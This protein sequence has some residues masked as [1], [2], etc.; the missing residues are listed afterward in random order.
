L[1]LLLLLLLPNQAR[2]LEQKREWALQLKRVILENYDAVIP[3]HARQLVLQLGQDQRCNQER[4]ASN[5]G[6][7]GYDRGDYAYSASASS[8]GSGG[9]SSAAHHVKRHQ[10]SAPE[11]LERRKHSTAGLAAKGRSRKGRK[12]S[13]DASS[14][15]EVSPSFQSFSFLFLYFI[16]FFHAR[17]FAPDL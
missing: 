11:Y 5:S 2:N 4:P 15:R 12:L 16:I 14:P 3:H 6:G 13:H 9:S 17:L 7:Q 10:H 1:T 8:A